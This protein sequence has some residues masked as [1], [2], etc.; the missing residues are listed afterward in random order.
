[1]SKNEKYSFS[2]KLNEFWLNQKN[3]PIFLESEFSEN[4]KK[5]WNKVI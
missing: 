2:N 4:E 1:M 5:D 3:I